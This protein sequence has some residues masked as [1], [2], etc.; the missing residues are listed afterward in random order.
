MRQLVVCLLALVP[1]SAV[2]AQPFRLAPAVAVEAEDFVIESGWKAIRN[3]QGNYMVDIVGFNH[4]SGERLLSLPAEARVGKAYLDVTIPVAGTYRLWVRYEY[5]PFSETRFRIVVEQGGKTLLD[6]VAGARDNPRYAFGEQTARPQ[7]DPPWGPE[8]LVE[9]GFTV[10][11][12]QAGPARLLLLGVEQPQKPGISANRNVDLVYLTSDTA[13]AWRKHYARITNLYPILDA[14]R[15]SR[16][17]R[18]QVRFTNRA[19]KPTT[20]RVAHSY[21]RIPWGNS[22]PATATLEPGQSSDWLGLAG[23]DTAHFSMAQFTASPAGAFDVEIRPVSGE[24]VRKLSGPGPHRLYLPTYPGKGEKPTTPEEAIDNILA[25][26]RQHQPPGKKPT[27]PLCYGGWMPL[28]QDSPYGRKYAQLY[29]ALGF[30]SLHPAH[31]GPAQLANLKAVGIEP[32]RSWMVMSYRNPPTRDNIARAR[33]E[34]Q[35]QG[36]AEQLRYFDYG[37]EIAFSEWISMLL[38]EDL[39]Q[40]RAVKSKA[41]EKDILHARWIAWLK[42]NRPKAQLSDYWLPSWGPLVPQ[43]L[44]PDSSAAAARERPRLYVDSLLFYEDTAIRFAAEGAKAVRAAL[45]E[46]VL[47]G[48]NYSCH[49]FYYPHS[50]SY[51]KWFR[52]GAADLGR[53]S[54]YFWQVGQLGPM[55][56][57][58][59]AEHFRSGM[60]DNPR[61]VLRQYTMPHSP[62]N[63]DLSLLRSALSHLAHGA[64]ELDFFG[65]GL[66]E[67]FTE[68][69]I[70]HR[71]VSRYRT[72]RDIT[73]LVGFVEDALP[74]A[75]AVPSG[76]ALLI[77][78]STERWD[79]AGIATDRAGHAH[80]G[81]EFRKTRLHFHLERLG[82]WKAL[83]FAGHSPDLLTEEDIIAGKFG[84]ARVLY[85]VGDHWPKQMIAALEKWIQQGGIVLATAAAG[86]R[87][88]YGEPISDWQRL[89]GLRSVQTRQQTT[90]V[91]PR[92]ELPFL[93]PLDRVRL[94]GGETFPVLA[95]HERIE[96]G[97]EVTVLARFASDDRPAWTLR[98]L[99]KG[100]I[101]YVAAHAGMAFLYT[102]V[103]PPT[104]PDRGPGSHQPPTAWDAVAAR[105]LRTPLEKAGLD[106]HPAHVGIQPATALL[107]LRLLE[108]P[109]AYLL[110]IAN[111]GPA[112]NA[113][114][115]LTLH[116]AQPIARVRS[117]YHGELPVRKLA[118]GIEVTLPLL[119]QGDLLR[120]DRAK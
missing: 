81:P 103:Q 26:L 74:V 60:R 105:L 25:H 115:R 3:G 97:E 114:V 116:P 20:F 68:N 29:A 84:A 45:G 12:L 10:S 67:T 73:H 99:G 32:T 106:T 56:N 28:G 82:I 119:S 83:T 86:Q 7:Y 98:T 19:D 13:D 2:V 14:F 39:A 33:Q 57:G 77:S 111:Y 71:D 79:Y 59:I 120:L 66:N 5:P 23:Q 46:H 22:D 85:V 107:D 78:E 72:L 1:L 96:P 17:P 48:P 31:S 53:H 89:A 112:L 30:R 102:A 69:H 9:E 24:V 21:N 108:A 63:T 8:G 6:R 55:I 109:T 62:G 27:L 16:G 91:R 18:W 64:K 92:Q 4:C 41:S 87:D 43:Q 52:G 51:I 40:A 50:T 34:L 44:R 42:N 90:F 11:G 70:D 113:P 38:Q 65:I 37:D 49:P 35:R 36:L 80:F 88:E 15:D 76:V 117:A 101:H 104:V 110:P 93:T 75:R 118:N 61:A 94:P 95:T 100:A 54:E 58:Y 47:S